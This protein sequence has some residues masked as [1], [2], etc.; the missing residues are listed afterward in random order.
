MNKPE[1]EFR[2]ICVEQHGH[3]ISNETFIF[4]K[5]IKPP[6]H[7]LTLKGNYNVAFNNCQHFVRRFFYQVSIPR[8][9]QDFVRLPIVAKELWLSGMSE[10][11][12]WDILHNIKSGELTVSCHHLSIAHK[13]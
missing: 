4:S 13:Y 11:N 2:N 9:G 1:E 12:I 10:N 8:N 6:R 5:Y 7:F 3:P